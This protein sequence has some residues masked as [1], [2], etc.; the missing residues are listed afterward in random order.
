MPEKEATLILKSGNCSWRNCIFC[1]YGRIAGQ[2]PTE[3]NLTREFDN[4]FSSLAERVDTIKVFGSG[5][6]LD[7]KQV[8]ENMRRNF[9]ARCAQRGIRNLL[10]ESR[11]EHIT[12]GKLSGF[13]S[14]KL[15]VAIGLEAA[16]D[17]ILEK[18]SKGFHTADYDKAVE[19]IRKA[20][21]NVRTYLLVN[22]PGE[23]E[24]TLEKSV[25]YALKR[26][27]S[28]VLIN[29]LPHG[30]TPL[31][32]LWINGEWNY[33]TKKQFMEKTEKW[34][35][36]PKIELDPETFK[37][38]PQFPPEL[39]K[40]LEGV[41]EEYLTHPY[42]EV[43]QDYLVRWYQPPKDRTPLMLP[44]SRKKPYSESETHKKIIS[45]LEE[46]GTRKGFHEVMI[47]N[48]GLIPRE[49]E[50]KYPFNQYDWDESLETPEIKERYVQVTEQRI[51]NY[52]KAH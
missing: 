20:G 17:Q 22:I 46:T 39:K 41:G 47:S 2:K 36:N 4:F 21:A 6:F 34:K 49:F 30:N 13:R 44:C 18:I 31:F 10:I 26:S 16:D 37:F 8:P 43:W 51:V 12:E 35:N 27:D 23:G 11:P 9:I 14:L 5:S 50:D 28:T 29:L 7:E 42:F 3:E 33:L 40:P 32:R 52:L 25:E 48:A 19:E 1:G 24:D 15:T 45:V 38:T